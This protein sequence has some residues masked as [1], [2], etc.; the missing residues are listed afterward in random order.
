M[1]KEEKKYLAKRINEIATQKINKFKQK[2]SI[3]DE[4]EYEIYSKYGKLDEKKIINEIKKLFK[5]NDIYVNSCNR[6][7]ISIYIDAEDSFANYKE[8]QSKVVESKKNIEEREKL[9]KNTIENFKEEI[10]ALIDEIMLQNSDLA[11]EKL[12]EFEKSELK[13]K[14]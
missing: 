14:E 4:K 9:I 2:Y 5:T 6:L 3:S 11:Y 13:I 7:S 1:N 12:K 8:V 10:N